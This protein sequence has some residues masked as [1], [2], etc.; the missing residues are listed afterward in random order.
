MKAYIIVILLML[1]GCSSTYRPHV[2]SHR[3]PIFLI[4]CATPA[5]PEE[6]AKLLM[7]KLK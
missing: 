5:Q 1:C 7:E 3:D 4:D 2:V 6:L